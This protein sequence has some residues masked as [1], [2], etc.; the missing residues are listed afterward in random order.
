MRAFP[1]LSLLV[2]TLAVVAC[3]DTEP[4]ATEL[5]LADL[6]QFQD[7][8]DDELVATTGTV[9]RFAEPEHYWIEDDA[10]NRIRVVPQPAVS[11]LVGKRVRVTGR[12]EYDSDTGRVIDA[13]TVEVVE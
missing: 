10:F 4:T 5:R 13:Q 12:F 11:D 1:T 8:Y 7:R 6:A 9:N 2:L 3:N